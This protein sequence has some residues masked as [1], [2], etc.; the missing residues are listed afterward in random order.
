MV[1]DSFVT[2]LSHIGI[3]VLDYA[4][5]RAFYERLGFEHAWG[6]RDRNRSPRCVARQAS[7]SP[8]GGVRRRSSPAILTT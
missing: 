2:G 1:T 8:G 6:R 4:K 5:A 7:R 3:R